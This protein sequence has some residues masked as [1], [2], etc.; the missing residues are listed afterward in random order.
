MN[1]DR[2]VIGMIGAG[3]ISR[4]HMPGL[5]R[6]A[7]QILIHSLEGA[8]ELADEC[9]GTVVL[10]LEELLDRADIVDI[11]TPTFTHYDLVRRCLEAGKDVI[12]EKPI[13]L[14]EQQASD[15]VRLADSLGRRLFPAHVVRYASEYALAKEAVDAGE[16][17]DL[18]VLRF[19]R[20]GSYPTRT[21]WFADMEKSGGILM[22]LSIHDVDVARWIAGEIVQVSATLRRTGTAEEPVD[23]GHILLTHASGAITHCSS[24]W[25]PSHL[26]FETEFSIA[27]TGGTLSHSS[28]EEAPVISTIT[29]DDEAAGLLPAT[30]PQS[31]PYA[32]ELQDFVTAITRGGGT[33]VTAEDGLQAVRVVSAALESVRR[34]Q[35]MVLATS[36]GSAK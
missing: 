15:L 24:L 9:G 21:A 11:V 8:Q 3:M 23:A 32:R 30:D 13:A 26:P 18:A 33:R 7:D 14:T 10:T 2:P 34:G 6:L 28:R 36:E 17:G 20:S 25:G 35:P 4:A 19:S 31:D 29:V 16:L 5:R 12:V 1:A 22:D 27:G